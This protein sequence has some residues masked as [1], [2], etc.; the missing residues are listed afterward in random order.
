MAGSRVPRR[1]RDTDALTALSDDA[2]PDFLELDRDSARL[3]EKP[4]A[5]DAAPARFAG[6]LPQ[7]I[8][9]LGEVEWIEKTTAHGPNRGFDVFYLRAPAGEVGSAVTNG[10]RFQNVT[11]VLPQELC[12]TLLAEQEEAAHRIVVQ[13]AEM[14]RDGGRGL[15]PEAIVAGDRPLA[16]GSATVGVV[17]AEHPFLDEDFNVVR[18]PDGRI[19]MQIITLIPATT[20]E[21]ALARARG[22]PELFDLWEEQETDLADLA[23][24]CA[25]EP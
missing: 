20:A 21:I 6:F 25:V 17:C 5:A 7:T 22:V 9:H 12:C 19:E 2:R 4:A 15:G 3:P 11:A 10:L 1:G 18:D 24:P 16:A 14:V 13:A 23:R 8:G